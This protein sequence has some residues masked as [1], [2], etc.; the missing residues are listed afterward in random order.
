MTRPVTN[1]KWLPYQHFNHLYTRIY[2]KDS[3]ICQ[4]IQ[5]LLLLK[6]IIL[7]PSTYILSLQGVR[8]IFK[9]DFC[10]TQITEELQ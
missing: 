10:E 1:N 9:R 7:T 8:I 4:G 3:G 5:I 6:H 2:C